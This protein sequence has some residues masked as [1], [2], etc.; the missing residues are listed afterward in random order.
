MKRY[1][2][3]LLESFF[4]I[5]QSEDYHKPTK[6]LTDVHKDER[7]D[8]KH[9]NVISIST[10]FRNR[11]IKSQ[12]RFSKGLLTL[13]HSFFVNCQE[14]TRSNNNVLNN[15]VV[16]RVW[17][18]KGPV[19]GLL[20]GSVGHVS[21]ELPNKYISLWPNDDKKRT[22]FTRHKSC[23]NS[24]DEDIADCGRDADLV[25]C[26]YTLNIVKMELEFDRLSSI[27]QWSLAGRNIIN[28][29]A[30]S[31]SGI[32]FDILITGGISE[33][34]E[35]DA[36][37]F[38]KT[39]KPILHT[40][41]HT[42]EPKTDPLTGRPTPSL[43]DMFLNDLFKPGDDLE[44]LQLAIISPNQIEKIIRC[45]KKHEVTRNPETWDFDKYSRGDASNPHENRS[46]VIQ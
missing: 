38:Y 11:P 27:I 34:L 5:I 28:S 42:D 14:Q 35:D 31:C 30:N 1:L 12:D 46:C 18:S 25:L 37:G 22:L 43:K 3:S 15:R 24:L 13:N 23:W 16:V 32:A 33:L 9:E 29:T 41:W 10:N 26:L 17:N 36:T 45:A 4:N 44:L 8:E 40:L 2:V 6:L 39:V 7:K 19:D 20:A 21:I